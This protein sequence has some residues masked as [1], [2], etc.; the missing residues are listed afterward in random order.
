MIHKKSTL[1]VVISVAINI[2]PLNSQ[3]QPFNTRQERGEFLSKCNAVFKFIYDK[4]KSGTEAQRKSMENII[5]GSQQDAMVYI[6]KND[7]EVIQK[8]EYAM[9]ERKMNRKYTID[10]HEFCTENYFNLYPKK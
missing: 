3:A 1:A 9:L 2:F 8:N 6:S 5:I 7:F 10:R 4:D